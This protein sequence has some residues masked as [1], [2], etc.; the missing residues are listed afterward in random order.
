MTYQAFLG[1]ATARRRYW[2]RSHVGWR[3]ILQAQ[4]NRGHVAVAELETRGFVSGTI[5]QNVDGLHTAAGSRRLIELHGRLDRVRC[6]ECDDVIPRQELDARLNAA[7]GDWRARVL[8]TNPDGDV[9]LADEAVE[10]FVVVGCLGCGGVLKPDVVYFGENVPP[11]R[12]SA[13]YAW[14]RDCSLL[15]VLGSSLT[16][17]SGR[18]FVMRAADAGIPVAIVNEGPTR[19][20]ARASLKLDEPLGETLTRL[21]QQLRS[22]DQLVNSA[23]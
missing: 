14:V 1:D 6:L 12:V 13:A 23:L 11:A 15:L 16:V 19:G 21:V 17:F 9:D 3:R 8:A 18:R 10:D 20:D 4:P 5:T 2:A 7:N 22:S